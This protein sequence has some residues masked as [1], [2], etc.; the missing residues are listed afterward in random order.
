MFAI[1]YQLDALLISSK[2]TVSF[3]VSATKWM[4]KIYVLPHVFAQT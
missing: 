4:P 1:A 3:F 2:Y